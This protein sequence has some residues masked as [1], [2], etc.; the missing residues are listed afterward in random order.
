[1]DLA[2]RI[3]RLIEYETKEAAFAALRVDQRAEQ[4]LVLLREHDP[5]LAAGKTA[6]DLSRPE[7]S[8]NETLFHWQSQSTTAEDSPTGQ[9]YI[10]HQKRGEPGAAVCPGVQNRPDHRWS[11]GVYLPGN[12]QLCRA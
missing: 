3:V 1:M 9:R 11:R 6:A 4:L 5:R 7:A 10:H 12:G 8:I 2:N